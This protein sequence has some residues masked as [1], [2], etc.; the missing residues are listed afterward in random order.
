MSKNFLPNVI[1]KLFDV[2]LPILKCINAHVPLAPKLQ[3]LILPH[4][5]AEKTF[6][7]R[8]PW[9]LNLTERSTSSEFVITLCGVPGYSYDLALC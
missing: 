9:F 8:V 6:S 1:P 3:L 5:S 2:S 7:L 4:E